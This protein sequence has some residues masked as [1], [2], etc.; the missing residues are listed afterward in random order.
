MFVVVRREHIRNGCLIGGVWI[1]RRLSYWDPLPKRH[2]R[3][4]KRHE[5]GGWRCE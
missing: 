2:Y 3:Y 4:R 1:K 5:D